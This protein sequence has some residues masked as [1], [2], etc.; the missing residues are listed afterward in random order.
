VG[1]PGSTQLLIYLNIQEFGIRHQEVLASM[2][3]ATAAAKDAF[4][5]VWVL[6]KDKP[7]RLWAAGSRVELPDGG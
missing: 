5:E 1:S 7:Y 2:H 6:W 4:A 3:D